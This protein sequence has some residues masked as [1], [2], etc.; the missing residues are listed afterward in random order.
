MLKKL[1]Y[2]LIV[3]TGL[4]IGDHSSAQA[5]EQVCI[6]LGGTGLA[7]A[8]DDTHLIASL[9]GSF[10]GGARAEI[11]ASKVTE[12]GL[13]MHMEHYFF[14]DKGG[15]LRTNDIATL[16]AV[17]GRDNV[18]MLEINYEIMASSGSYDDYEGRFQSFGLIDLDKGQVVLRYQ[19]KICK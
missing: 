11:L 12:T 14:N 13:S 7:N 8:V 5:A 19:G 9:S 10:A 4:V 18:H 1:F 3:S 17:P 6:D 15:L 2:G 16:T